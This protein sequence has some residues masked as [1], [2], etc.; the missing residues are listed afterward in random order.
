M[1]IELEKYKEYLESRVD[2]QAP[3]TKPRK[4]KQMQV[5]EQ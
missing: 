1:N 3:L 4:S 2:D 5:T